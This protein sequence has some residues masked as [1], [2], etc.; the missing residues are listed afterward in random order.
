MEFSFCEEKH[1]REGVML[2]REC[3]RSR[4][5][6]SHHLENKDQ[7]HPLTKMQKW[8]QRAEGTCNK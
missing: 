8:K 4:I 5:R 6:L 3:M 7:I 1:A 2:E